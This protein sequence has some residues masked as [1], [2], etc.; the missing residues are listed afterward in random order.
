M[1]SA[2]ARDPRKVYTERFIFMLALLIP[3]AYLMGARV[4]VISAVSVAAAF[5]FDM[6][7]CRL[8]KIPFDA[9]D[10]CVPFWALSAAMLMSSGISLWLV[11]LSSFIIVALGKHVFGEADN[12]IFSPAAISAAFLIICYPIDML[13]YPKSGEIY[14]LFSEF[15]GVFTRGI[16]YTM[17]LGL[18]PTNS[19]MDILMGAVPGAFGAVNIMIILVCGICL[20]IRRSNSVSA[21]VSCLVTAGVLAFAYPRADVSGLMSV[22]YEFS[23]GYFLFGVFFMAAEPYILP[24]CLGGRIIYGVVLG[25]TVMMFRNFG[26]TEGSFIFALLIVN[27]LSGCFDTIV[28]NISYW[29][30]SYINSYEQNKTEVQHGSVKLTDT[31][32]IVLP[33]KYRYN[34][35]PVDGEIKKHR[36]RARKEDND[37]EQ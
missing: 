14:P 19:V 8:R 24:K 23:S 1:I 4:L 22:F 33:E 12:I 6:L 31:Q 18:A 5:V 26:Q 21:V 29:K 15:N 9:K 10:C 17:K 11:V 25:Y 3:A 34:T 28:E 13:Y 32:E 20:L 35:P 7:F 30:K 27:A 2:P 16:E 36:R 37:A